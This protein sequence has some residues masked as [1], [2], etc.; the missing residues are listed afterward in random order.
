MS[1]DDANLPPI[2]F[3]AAGD[4]S[5]QQA[6]NLKLV[7]P[8]PGFLPM[9][10]FCVDVT[11]RN[12]DV[13]V[14]DFTANQANIRFKI[15]GIWQAGPTL[16]REDGDYLLATLKQIAGMDYRERRQHQAGSFKALF[17]KKNYKFKVESQ[18]VKTGERVAVHLDYKRPPLET[19]EELG[20]RAKMKT[21]IGAMIA[22]PEMGNLLVIGYPNGNGHTSAWKAVLGCADRLTRDFY[23]LQPASRGDAE[24][25]INVYP[26]EYDPAKGDNPLSTLPDLLLK[27]PDVLA[28][29]D[30][31]SAEIIDQIIELSLSRKLPIFTRHPGKHCLDGMLR[32]IAKKPNAKQFLNHLSGVV[33]MRI[34]RKLCDSCKVAYTPHPKLLQQLGLPVG[35]VAELYQPFVCKP[36]MLDE[37]EVPIV[38]CHKCSGV[39]F[40]GRTGIFEFLTMTDQLK[41]AALQK[42]QLA[43]LQAVAQKDGHVSMKLEGV[44]MIAKGLTSVD[45]LQRVLKG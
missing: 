15:D 35:R 28:F 36:G 43:H 16:E 23:V 38:P 25:V 37:D 20:M 12:A 7:E 14:M 40:K 2:E 42:P 27:Q 34:I 31:D 33:S 13:T 22:D 11:Q 21:E 32:V 3:T 8:S 44:L 45:E 10:L 30:L 4:S 29:P 9:A 18:G 41:S 17:R 26:W 5:E 6:H 1:Y 24:E 39:G 19:A